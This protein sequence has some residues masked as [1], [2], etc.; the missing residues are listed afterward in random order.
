MCTS[1]KKGLKT[2]N[3]NYSEGKWK[4]ANDFKET[5]MQKKG[6]MQQNLLR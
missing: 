1:D 6:G 4:A 5:N 3:K 2:E